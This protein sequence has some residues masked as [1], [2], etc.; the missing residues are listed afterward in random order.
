MSS[1]TVDRSRMRNFI[2][3]VVSSFVIGLSVIGS[4]IGESA[5]V[6]SAMSPVNCSKECG[7]YSGE[8]V[9]GASS[10]VVVSVISVVVVLSVVVG[11]LV[12][13]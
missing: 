5:S 11:R 8:V 2:F 3:V 4:S 9:A 6:S 12:V 1:V 13:G 7:L 10:V